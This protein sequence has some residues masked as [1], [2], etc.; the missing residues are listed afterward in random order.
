MSVIP[1]NKAPLASVTVPTDQFCVYMHR[2]D[3]KLIYIGSGTFLRA[4][5]FSCR[6][7][8]WFNATDKCQKV[9]VEIVGCFPTRS[10][11]YKHER[12]LIRRFRP[13]ANL[14]KRHPENHPRKSSQINIRLDPELFEKLQHIARLENRPLAQLARIALREYLERRAVAA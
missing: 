10:A 13:P 6:N 12:K 3:D 7:G 1:I 9:T 2:V 14:R 11:A 8:S 5:N 4:F